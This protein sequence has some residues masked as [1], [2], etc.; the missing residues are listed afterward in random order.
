[1]GFPSLHENI[2]ERLNEAL[3]TLYGD[4]ERGYQSRSVS[5]QEARLKAIGRVQQ[6]IGQ[7]LEEHLEI[8]TTPGIE[9]TEMVKKKEAKIAALEEENAKL[10]NKLILEQQRTQTTIEAVKQR[11]AKINE[12]QNENDRLLMKVA[13]LNV[14]E[15][16]G[17]GGPVRSR[18]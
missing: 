15:N 3:S 11:D 6:Q 5:E 18:R 7:L 14:K 8:A 13:F 4:I 16:G 9:L 1:M 17:R 12:L 10:R 2:L